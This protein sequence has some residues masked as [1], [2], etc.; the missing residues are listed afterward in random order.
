MKFYTKVLFLIL[1]MYSHIFVLHANSQTV[2]NINEDHVSYSGI[3][4]CNSIFYLFKQNDLN[5]KTQNLISSGENILPYNIIIEKK[6]KSNNNSLVIIL[7]IEDVYYNQELTLNLIKSIYNKH[8]NISFIITYSD[9][10]SFFYKGMVNGSQAYLSLINKNENFNVLLIELDKN[11][12]EIISGGFGRTSP[13][14]MVKNLNSAYL[15]ENIKNNIGKFHLSLISKSQF[16]KVT[17]LATYLLNEIP[18]ICA[19]FDINSTSNQQ[20]INVISN[21]VDSYFN[22]SDTLHIQN[23]VHYLYFNLFNKQIWLSENT[24][25]KIMLILVFSSLIIVFSI[26]FI[27]SNLKRQAWLEIKNNLYA[28]VS[29]FLL[30]FIGSLVGHFIFKLIYNSKQ[31]ISMVVTRPF[32]IAILQLSISILFVSFFFLA[33]MFYKKKYINPDSIDFLIMIS[34]FTNQFLFCL[35]DISLFPIFLI[36][37]LL[38]ILSVIVKKNWIHMIIFLSMIF[39]FFPL[40]FKIYFNSDSSALYLYLYNK[41]FYNIYF[42]LILMPIFLVWYR[43]IHAIKKHFPKRWLFLTITIS[44]YS[45]EILTMILLNFTIFNK[46]PSQLTK[47]SRNEYIESKN[48]IILNV[49]DEKIFEDTIRTLNIETTHQPEY[50]SIQVQGKDSNPVLFS[51]NEFIS[52]SPTSSVF[53]MPT[54]PPKNLKITYGTDTNLSKI[55]VELVYKLN[56]KLYI[57]TVT[58]QVGEK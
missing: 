6:S 15:D 56:D 29:I 35:I 4:L 53:R 45:I 24:I 44:V 1:Y 50:I 2:A 5:P 10:Q 37:F 22:E 19:N 48:N 49:S 47:I 20:I 40:L 55:N 39:T 58:H 26:G 16:Y 27:N 41:W 25:V 33:E 54:N 43:I 13:L 57:E 14:W 3:E 52:D 31:S 9:N 23:D 30:S 7:K 42:S 28:I 8:E 34:T 51:D 38:S 18:S 21:F 32:S 11:K 17:P 36:I 46:K 12:N